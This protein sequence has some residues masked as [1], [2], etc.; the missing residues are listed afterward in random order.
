M[1]YSVLVEQDLRRLFVDFDA[2]EDCA[3][4][5]HYSELQALDSKRYKPMSTHPRIYPQSFAPIIVAD[6]QQLLVKPMRYRLR[7]HGSAQEVPSK[8]NLFNARLEG[9]ETRQTWSALF[10]RKHGLLVA[11]AFYEWVLRDGRKQ[12]ISF[13]PREHRDILIPVLYDEWEDPAGRETFASF[14]LITGE[15]PP[16]VTEAGHD[17]CPLFLRRPYIETWL[18][19][20]QATRTR[21]KQLLTDRE[22]AYFEHQNAEP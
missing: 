10:M 15:P 20:W 8:Y 14:A 22:P 21:M 2:L 17:R 13:R 9:L 1:C 6:E 11:Q 7:P 19:P 4:F 18:R 16:E 12:V 5:A 3:A